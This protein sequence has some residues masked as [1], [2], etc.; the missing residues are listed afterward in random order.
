[1]GCW[2][3][4]WLGHADL[5]TSNSSP[6]STNHFPTQPGEGLEVAKSQTF[7]TFYPPTASPQPPDTV[8]PLK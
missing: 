6:A 8:S 7:L 2:Q 5:E 3:L 1:M 4:H